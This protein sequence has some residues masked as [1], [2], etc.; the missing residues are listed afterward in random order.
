MSLTS[1]INY[2]E[3]PISL[4]RQASIAKNASVLTDI[5]HEENHIVIWQNQFTS[6]LLSE[7]N[8]IMDKAERL[9]IRLTSAPANLSKILPTCADVLHG[10]TA[11]CHYIE[12]LADMFCT[13]FDIKRVGL[14]L[15]ILSQAMCP[16]FHVDKVPCRL[17]STFSGIATQWLPHEK[18]DRSKLGMGSLGVADDKSGIMKEPQDIKTMIAG[19][20]ALLKGEGWY[21]NENGGAVHRSPPLNKN[22]KRL[23]LTLD[24]SD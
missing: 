10:K 7:I 22:E 23:L 15:A 24:F 18:V 13:L 8:Q 5:Y 16:K 1:N 14:R 21:N 19:D 12:L 6:A 3:V 9:N 11:L 20:V 2:A 4:S 17:V